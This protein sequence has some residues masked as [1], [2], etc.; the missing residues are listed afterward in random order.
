M[1]PTETTFL[2]VLGGITP[3]DIRREARKAKITVTANNN[4]DHLLHHKVTA[5]KTS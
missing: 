2:H 3:L 5:A 1:R 4:T